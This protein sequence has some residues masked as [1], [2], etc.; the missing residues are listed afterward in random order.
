VDGYG[1]DGYM[2]WAAGGAPNRPW[3]TGCAVRRHRR[4]L[5][6]VNNNATAS[7]SR[8]PEVAGTRAALSV[9]KTVLGMVSRKL[10]GATTTQP[11][12]PR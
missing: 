10:L 5:N 8:M 12:T 11:S 2:G 7:T 9:P 4:G 3:L 1:V 6:T